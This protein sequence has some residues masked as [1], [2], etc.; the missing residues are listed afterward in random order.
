MLYLQSTSK[1]LIHPHIP[2]SNIYR[3]YGTPHKRRA[4]VAKKRVYKKTKRVSDA[5]TLAETD[6]E[7]Y[8]GMDVDEDLS[9][10]DLDE[11]LIDKSNLAMEKLA[12]TH[13]GEAFTAFTQFIDDTNGHL[14]TTR[15]KGAER[16]ARAFVEAFT[17]EEARGDM[18]ADST[19]Y[20]LNHLGEM[21][22]VKLFVSMS[23]K[24]KSERESGRS[25]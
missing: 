4:P 3:T 10:N 25:L 14:Y 7:G 18:S 24:L 11:Q 22:Q 2:R 12:S 13:A 5:T 19:G 6:E 15:S 23:K 1:C 8:S 17:R 9:E 16:S 20:W 21:D